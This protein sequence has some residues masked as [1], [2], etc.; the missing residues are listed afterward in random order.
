MQTLE[1]QALQ[2]GIS[3]FELTV[4]TH[5]KIAVNLYKKMGYVIE[6]NIKNSMFIN[7]EFVNEYSMAKVV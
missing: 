4:M 2:N 1:K 7:E 6:G 3:R 5:N